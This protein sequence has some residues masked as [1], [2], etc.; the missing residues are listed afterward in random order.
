MNAQ[1]RWNP[2]PIQGSSWRTQLIMFWWGRVSVMLKDQSGRAFSGCCLLNAV[3]CRRVSIWRVWQLA[4]RVLPFW[5]SLISL[6]HLQPPSG[7]NDYQLLVPAGTLGFAGYQFW[8]PSARSGFGDIWSQLQRPWLLMSLLDT[9]DSILMS[10]ILLHDILYCIEID[11][12]L[13]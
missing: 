5:R 6:G 8:E 3:R 11:C 4:A 2:C 9:R 1:L 10:T 12:S 7:S 13:I